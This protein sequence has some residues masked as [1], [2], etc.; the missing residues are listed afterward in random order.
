[1]Q[2]EAM[3]KD[4][5]AAF[6][7][8]LSYLGE[9]PSRE[10]FARALSFSAFDR[11]RQQEQ[12]H[13]FIEQPAISRGAFFRAGRPGEW[14]MTLTQAQQGRIETDHAVEMRRFGYL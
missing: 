4:P 3:V 9:D 1:M 5:A 6:A 14:Q 13:G 8:M 12:A 11:L 7:A 2:Y 10:R